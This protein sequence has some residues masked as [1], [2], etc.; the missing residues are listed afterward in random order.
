MAKIIKITPTSHTSQTANPFRTSRNSV[1]N[2]FKYSNF[3]GNTL[4]F[5]DVFE[6]FEPKS[7]SKMRLIAS[8]VAGTM[9]KM[10]TGIGQSIVNLV[11][12]VTSAWEYAK[13]T[14][15]SDLAA[16]KKFT[17]IMATPIE[18]PGS[19]AIDSLKERISANI[20]ALNENIAGYGKE[21]GAKWQALISKIQPKKL[22]S[23]IPVAELERL[24]KEELAAIEMR[25]AA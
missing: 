12:K 11:N 1:S 16:V 6:G 9:H 24:W 25:G 23:D 21:L 4:Q 8:S 14:N 10:K 22:T 5:A 20:G 17:D 18:L 15:I 3:E 19:K 13:N 7:T 2:P